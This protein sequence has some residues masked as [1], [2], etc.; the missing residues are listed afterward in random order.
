MNK[1]MSFKQYRLL[2]KH[3]RVTNLSELSEKSSLEYHPPQNILKETE[4]LRQ[5]S[6]TLWTSGKKMCIDEARVASKSKR[7]QFKIRNP[8]KPVRIGW[9]I[10]KVAKVG[11]K[12]GSF[13]FN[14]FVKVGKATYTDVSKGKHTVRSNYFSLMQ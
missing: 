13:V 11:L 4:H 5:K 8:D 7:N 12:G 2:R 14:H 10:N 6:N 1:I 9:T 3:F